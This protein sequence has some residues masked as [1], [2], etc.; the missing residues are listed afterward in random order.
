MTSSP[1]R[2]FNAAKLLQTDINAWMT[3]SFAKCTEKQ[4]CLGGPRGTCART[5]G[6]PLC[7]HEGRERMKTVPPGKKWR[8]NKTHARETP[9]ERQLRRDGEALMR[10]NEEL[11]RLRIK[12]TA[13]RIKHC[14]GNDAPFRGW[15]EI[16]DNNL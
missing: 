1:S 5:D 11:L 8:T 16:A 15:P 3:C 2:R 13:T 10:I 12:E 14:T 7:T 4:A 6:W 9:G